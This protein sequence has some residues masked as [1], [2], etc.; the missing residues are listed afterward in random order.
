MF[1]RTCYTVF[2]LTFVPPVVM[3]VVMVV[4][5]QGDPD[6]GLIVKR[7]THSCDRSVYGGCPSSLSLL[8]REVASCCGICTGE[9]EVQLIRV[10]QTQCP[11]ISVLNFISYTFCHL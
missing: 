7:S 4:E 5:L 10:Q 11:D 2:V 8:Q 9:L 6:L 3:V 1:V